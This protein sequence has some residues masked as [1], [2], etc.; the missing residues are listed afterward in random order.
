MSHNNIV[1]NVCKLPSNEITES[2]MTSV[3]KCKNNTHAYIEFYACILRCVNYSYNVFTYKHLHHLV[4]QLWMDIP[5]FENIQLRERMISIALP[6]GIPEI[7]MDKIKMNCREWFG[8]S[9]NSTIRLLEHLCTID[10]SDKF[11]N[12][13]AKYNQ[14]IKL[15]IVD[16]SRKKCHII[17]QHEYEKK[18]ILAKT[19]GLCKFSRQGFECKYGDKCKFYHGIVESTFGFQPCKHT[20]ENCNAFKKNACRFLHQVPELKLKFLKKFYKSLSKTNYIVDD[21]YSTQID[22]LIFNDAFVILEKIANNQ[23][24]LPTCNC[25]ATNEYG[26]SYK[27]DAPVRIMSLL[28]CK[29]Y[30]SFEHKFQIENKTHYVVKQNTL[31]LID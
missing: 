8:A 20:N 30:C 13:W 26:F 12:C 24:C 18:Q 14:H 15:S 28:T 19:N 11:A 2:I 16:K 29:Y 31:H 27:C 10:K 6:Y 3:I 22:H 21:V 5:S 17:T 4:L 25:R 1:L 7:F 9:D 23:Y